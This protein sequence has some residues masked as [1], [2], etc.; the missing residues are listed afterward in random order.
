MYVRIHDWVYTCHDTH[1]SLMHCFL[2]IMHRARKVSMLMAAVAS[3][4]GSDIR[5]TVFMCVCV[6]LLGPAG[7]W[8][9]PTWDKAYRGSPNL[10]INIL[11]LALHANHDVGRPEFLRMWSSLPCEWLSRPFTSIHQQFFSRD[12]LTSPALP[13]DLLDIIQ[14]IIKWM[15]G[16]GESLVLS[17]EILPITWL[18]WRWSGGRGLTRWI[19]RNHN[20][21]SSF[22]WM[23][24]L[25]QEFVVSL[26]IPQNI[27]IHTGICC[28]FVYPSEYLHSHRN[29]LCLY[30]CPFSI[31]TFTYHF[32]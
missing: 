19:F 5:R 28:V 1:P 31:I 8:Y 29:L 24:S 32:Q 15:C 17:W 6:W 2:V 16:G 27:F 23:S 20:I 14:G 12:S 10:Q 4:I 21:N 25:T 7:S 13:P 26:Y 9:Y 30:I 11:T 18:S 22:R 3:M